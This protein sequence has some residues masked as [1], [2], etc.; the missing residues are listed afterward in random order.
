MAV[1]SRREALSVT[2]YT[3]HEP[4]MMEC[5]VTD[6]TQSLVKGQSTLRSCQ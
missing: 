3:G 5:V 6:G 4:L 1:T 2:W